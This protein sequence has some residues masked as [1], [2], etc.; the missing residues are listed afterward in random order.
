[1]KLI[2]ALFFIVTTFLY[3]IVDIKQSL[4]TISVIATMLNIHNSYKNFSYLESM[5]LTLIITFLKGFCIEVCV[6]N[7]FV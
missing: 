3:D 7:I 4:Y 1:M 2:F 6:I 5:V